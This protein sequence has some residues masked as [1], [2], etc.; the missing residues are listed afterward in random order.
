MMWSG[1]FLRLPK[2]ANRARFADHRVYRYQG[3]VVDRQVHL[4]ADLASVQQSPVPAANSGRVVFADSVGIYGNTVVIDH[5]FGLM[6]LYSHL[7][8][9]GIEVGARVSRGDIIG[10]TGVSGLA[11]GDH[12]HFGMMVNDTFVNPIEWWDGH[13][14]KDNILNKIKLVASAAG[15]GS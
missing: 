3:K 8:T 15:N 4:G 1:S 9:I 13:W 10:K 7:S 12:L 6:S 14:I 2:S 5:G 11:V